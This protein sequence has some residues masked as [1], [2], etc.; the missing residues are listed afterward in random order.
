M[1]TLKAAHRIGRGGM[2]AAVIA[3]AAMG[4]GAAHADVGVLRYVLVN[5]TQRTVDEVRLRDTGTDLPD[6]NYLQRAVGP[7]GK[8]P[9][10][11]PGIDDSSCTRGTWVHFTDGAAVKGNVDYCGEGQRL[12]VY[13][14]SVKID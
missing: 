5:H 2:F 13:D 11:L 9:L 10:E 14:R 4:P 1:K 8:S 6:E 7:G 12:H 3:S